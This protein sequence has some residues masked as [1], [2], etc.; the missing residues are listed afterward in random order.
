MTKY[1]L[2]KLK[3]AVTFFNLELIYTLRIGLFLLTAILG[4]S[5]N[6]IGQTVDLSTYI[7]VGRY[8]L[9][10]PTRTVY[11]LK[12]KPVETFEFENAS[13]AQNQK[14]GSNYSSG[15][16]NIMVAQGRNKKTIRVIKK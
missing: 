16:Y 13:D 8:D 14:I 2:L 3:N 7:R 11:D 5:Q 9:P 6:S 15:I 1:L 4:F 10:E 12:G